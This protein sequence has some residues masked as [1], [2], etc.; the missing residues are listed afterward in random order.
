ME[1]ESVVRGERSFRQGRGRYFQN[2]REELFS[3]DNIPVGKDVGWLRAMFNK[4][5]QLMDVFIPA[6]GRRAS[7]SRFG[8]VRFK[9]LG[10]ANAAVRRWNGANVGKEKLRVMLED[11]G[12]KPRSDCRF[13]GRG[14]EY[15][16]R[17]LGEEGVEPAR[18]PKST[19]VDQIL[20]GNKEVIN[21]QNC[22]KR[23]VELEAFE[24]QEEWLNNTL[25]AEMKTIKLGEDLEKELRA[26]GISLVKVVPMGGRKV[27][28]QFASVEDL[29]R[30]LSEDYSSVL[31]NFSLMKRWREKDVPTTRSV[32]ISVLGLPFKAWTESNCERL[33]APFGVF[34][35]M[36][37][38]DVRFVGVGRA[39]MLIDTSM[40]GR[41]SEILE[42]EISGRVYEISLCEDCCLGGCGI[43][44]PQSLVEGGNSDGNV[45][46]RYREDDRWESEGDENHHG[47]DAVK[48]AYPGQGSLETNQFVPNSP[49]GKEVICV[50]SLDRTVG[51]EVDVGKLASNWVVPE[52]SWDATLSSFLQ[53]IGKGVWGRG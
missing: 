15:N 33:S 30:F 43:D 45:G 39:R 17:C 22:K 19:R 34:L 20:Q 41:I 4:V 2:L 29:E 25:V 37:D 21:G 26:E 38:R 7:N 51:K 11:V 53:Q 47:S 6:K 5:G 28:I 50:S 35:K 13:E 14:L 24:E 31:R 52:I 23:R 40:V 16:W 36:D 48:S 44:S 18:S 10:E 46:V 27:L 12:G 9:T 3:I 8:F 1:K 32:W 49:S 42:A